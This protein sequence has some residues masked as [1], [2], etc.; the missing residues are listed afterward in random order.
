[1]ELVGKPAGPNHKN[2]IIGISSL[3]FLLVALSVTVAAFGR[4]TSYQSEAWGGFRQRT[5]SQQVPGTDPN[6]QSAIPC[7]PVTWYP[8][9]L[10]SS[11]SMLYVTGKVCNN[12]NQRRSIDFQVDAIAGTKFLNY[13]THS[14]TTIDKMTWNTC[15]DF[16]VTFNVKPEWCAS[17]QAA[18][19]PLVFE[20]QY[21][22]HQ[23]STWTS[24]GSVTADPGDLCPPS[25]PTPSPTSCRSDNA[26]CDNDRQCCSLKCGADRRC[27]PK[28][29]APTPTPIA[30]RPPEISSINPN[31][32]VPLYR[33]SIVGENFGTSRGSICFEV[34]NRAVCNE[35]QF[36]ITAWKT[37]VILASVVETPAL[38][39]AGRLWVMVGG[40]A[41]ISSNHVGFVVGPLTVGTT[42]PINNDFAPSP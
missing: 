32:V 41:N 14:V 28:S 11:T 38:R 42:P 2:F 33:F 9:R 17:G 19:N 29:S 10:I 18:L 27:G 34:G 23:D 36:Q 1:M 24:L 22:L 16:G 35:E 7:L 3:A 25:K 39:G 15:R 4:R 12:C 5:P 31:F 8:L 20:R 37:G 40:A 26:Q 6:A 30:V 21:K 13:P